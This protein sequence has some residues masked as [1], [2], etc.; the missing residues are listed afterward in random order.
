[1]SRTELIGSICSIANGSDYSAKQKSDAR[2]LLEQLTARRIDE[3]TAQ[4]QYQLIVESANTP[5]WV[6]KLKPKAVYESMKL[7]QRGPLDSISKAKMISSLITH[8][9]IELQKNDS[10]SIES[11]GLG[12]LSECLHL[13]VSS[14]LNEN[15]DSQ[16]DDI[17]HKYGYLRKEGE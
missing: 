1:M 11:M 13:L 4:E 7:Y 8:G 12:E 5:Y 6:D 14:H 15:I 9:L 10:A 17:L 16:L 3:A 2:L